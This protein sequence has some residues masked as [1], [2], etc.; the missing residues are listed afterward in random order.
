MFNLTLSACQTS[1]HKPISKQEEQ[2]TQEEKPATTPIQPEEP[3]NKGPEYTEE[4]N[5]IFAQ[6][7]IQQF[8]YDYF[9]RLEAIGNNHLY[10]YVENE[11]LDGHHYHQIG[12]A[13]AIR[14]LK[15]NYFR[16]WAR[17][18]GYD[19]NTVQP[20]LLTIKADNGTTIA[21]EIREQGGQMKLVD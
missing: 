7:A 16:T 20:P 2:I 4:S 9:L 19:L 14:G 12:Y 10:I 5:Q 15:D 8:G 18:N 1:E 6:Y 17:E 3:S 13:D 11:F 21:E